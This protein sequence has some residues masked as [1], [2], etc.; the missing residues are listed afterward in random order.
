MGNKKGMKQ[1]FYWLG[2]VID[3]AKFCRYCPQCQ[4]SKFNGKP[5]NANFISIPSMTEPF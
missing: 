5:I 1:G 3:V 2:I 4:R